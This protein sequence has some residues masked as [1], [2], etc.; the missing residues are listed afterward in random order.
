MSQKTKPVK[1]GGN[2]TASGGPPSADHVYGIKRDRGRT[3]FGSGLVPPAA[4]KL[5]KAQLDE[6]KRL[7]NGPQHSYGKGRVRVHNNL[8]RHGLAMIGHS[9]GFMCWITQAGR[10]FLAKAAR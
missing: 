4:V 10:D 5:T 1:R 9:D 3:G 8:R 2:D 7:A 6:L